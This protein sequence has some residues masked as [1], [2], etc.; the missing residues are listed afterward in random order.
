MMKESLTIQ[1]IAIAIERK[2]IKNMYLKVR[3]PSGEVVI[4]APKKMKREVIKMFAIQKLPWIKKQQQKIQSQPRETPHLYIDNESHYLWGKSYFLKIMEGNHSPQISVAGKTLLL[5]LPPNT[6]FEQKKAIVSDWYRRQLRQAIP[7]IITQWQP[8][9]GV[10][11]NKFFIQQ[12]KTKW[13]SCNVTLGNIRLNLELAKKPP[14]CL[15][16]VVVHEM[17]PLLEAS[18]NHRFK[19]LMDQFMPSWRHHQQT[20]K[21]FPLISGES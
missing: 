14:Q 16:Y 20:L 15:E 12:M 8:M 19:S 7:P 5:H 1:G 2:N 3:P 4:S 17:T 11:V 21:N 9:M 18:H 6:S 10:T 13:G